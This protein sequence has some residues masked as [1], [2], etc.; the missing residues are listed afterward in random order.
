MRQFPFVIEYRA[1]IAH[2]EP[3]AQA[4]PFAEIIVLVERRTPMHCGLVTGA[5]IRAEIEAMRRAETSPD[6]GLRSGASGRAEL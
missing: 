4:S 2:V 5:F 3:A 1:E 6:Y